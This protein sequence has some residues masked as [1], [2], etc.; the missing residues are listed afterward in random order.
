MHKH[1]SARG[2]SRR[3]PETTHS[4]VRPLKPT[5]IT[6]WKRIQ[7]SLKP[8]WCWRKAA[9][10]KSFLIT[11]SKQPTTARAPRSW[12]ERQHQTNLC[13]EHNKRFHVF[14]SKDHTLIHS[15][16]CLIKALKL[17]ECVCVRAWVS[18]C[19][20]C[21][22]ACLPV[23]IYVFICVFCPLSTT[24]VHAHPC[25]TRGTQL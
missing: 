11:A 14:S 10:E 1:T 23:H 15:A 8:I 18:V 17:C 25:E 6:K 19:G 24:Y 9:D 5:Y 12:V 7:Q 4:H 13:S 22:L 3:K 2:Q 20:V 16:V 21:V